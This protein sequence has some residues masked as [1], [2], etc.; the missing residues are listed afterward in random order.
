MIGHRALL[1]VAGILTAGSA[2]AQQ[3]VF[4]RDTLSSIGR[5]HP[6][7][8]DAEPLRQIQAVL[9]DP[10]C[11]RAEERGHDPRLFVRHISRSPRL[12]KLGIEPIEHLLIG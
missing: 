1:V 6:L 10:A 5:L 4:M 3:G 9:A 7:D 2:Q 8:L 12:A 11:H